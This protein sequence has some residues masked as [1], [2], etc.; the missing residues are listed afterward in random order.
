MLNKTNE[1][2][3]VFGQKQV[4][5]CLHGIIK[6][7]PAGTITDLQTDLIKALTNSSDD[8]CLALRLSCGGEEGTSECLFQF[9]SLLIPTV[10]TGKFN[11]TVVSSGVTWIH[12][13]ISLL[14]AFCCRSLFS[15]MDTSS[16]LQSC[17]CSPWIGR[18]FGFLLIL[19]SASVFLSACFFSFLSSTAKSKT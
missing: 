12:S 4:D 6:H 18:S 10:S 14:F 17:T 1:E 3:D 5:F 9:I 16:S 8:L 7:L 15:A 13:S 19:S 11:L 2:L